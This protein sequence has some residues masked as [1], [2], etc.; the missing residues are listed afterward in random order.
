MAAAAPREAALREADRRAEVLVRERRLAEA[1]AIHERMACVA[2]DTA[3]VLVQLGRVLLLGDDAGR[4]LAHFEALT[5]RFPQSEGA[6]QGLGKAYYDQHRCDDAVAAFTRA[7]ELAAAPALA[8]YHRGMARLLAGDFEAGWRDYE[9]RFAVPALRPRNFERARWDG[10]PL[11]GRRLLV[12]CEQGYGDVF[13]FIRTLPS[14]RALGGTVVFECPNELRALLA[15]L[16]EGID[17]VPLTGMGPPDTPFDCYAPLMSLPHL[18]GMTLANLPREVPYLHAAPVE[19]R[20]PAALLRV[21][22]CWAGSPT[23]PQDLHRSMHPEFLAPL[24]RVPGVTLVSLQK[25]TRHWPVLPGLGEFLHPPPIP[26]DDFMA[27]ARVIAG[28]DLTITVDS[29][30]AHLAGALGRPVWL[31]LS[32]DGEWRWLLARADSPWYPGMRIYR[33]ERLGAW[34]ALIEEVRAALVLQVASRS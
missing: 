24:A 26:L 14:L 16:L 15:P 13:Q 18:T 5:R 20:A 30:V 34:D 31:L 22:V 27:T 9:H 29:A 4:A 33:Q 23:H 12:V 17:V 11:A 3:W 2:P 10:S 32:R 28:L 8:L 1:L 21:G 25:D 7:A 19:A 6:W